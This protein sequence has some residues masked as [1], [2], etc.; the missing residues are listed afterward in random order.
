MERTNTVETKNVARYLS[1]KLQNITMHSN[2][3]LPVEE[4]S[5]K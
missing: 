5:A 1:Q 2:Y 4:I 3:E